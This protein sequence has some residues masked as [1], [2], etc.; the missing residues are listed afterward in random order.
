MATPE[1]LARLVQQD[2]TQEVTGLEQGL[3]AVIL[4]DIDA[5]F[6][7]LVAGTVAA[8][9]T[10][11]GAPDALAV[12]GVALRRLLAAV[13]SAV[14]RII[15][16]LGERAAVALVDA[17]PSVAAVAV[18]QSAAFVRAASGRPSR[19]VPSRANRGLIAH[20]GA[21]ADAVAE[22]LGRA[23]AALRTPEVQRWS[24]VVTAV[25]I[26]R[27]STS[28]VRQH[29]VTTIS[30][31]VNDV[32]HRSVL[33]LDAR[34]LWIAEAD[35]C[36]NCSAYSGL[37]VAAGAPFPGGLSWD[38]H[39]RHTAAPGVDH[40]PL[41]PH[42]R[43]RAVPWMPL[44]EVGEVPLPLYLQRQARSNI[45]HGLAG[46]NESR[47]ARVRAAVELLGSGVA[48]PPDVRA[49]ARRAVRNRRFAAA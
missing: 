7:T 49:A 3:L 11:F 18:R 48:L 8:W 12:P 28:T 33:R 42:C 6:T 13:R 44:W 15:G 26:A 14:R 25:G 20:A 37:T 2:H 31:T 24:D 1:E 30:E 45:A 40:P 4:G 41:H 5:R 10:A 46:P 36:V 32:L 21:V 17:L 43:C 23:L 34:Q 9:T 16:D 39:Q 47:A 29:V 35:A 19:T 38:P 22:R 27:G